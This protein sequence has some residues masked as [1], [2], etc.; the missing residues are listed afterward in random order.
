MA[1]H[2]CIVGGMFSAALLG[3]FCLENIQLLHWEEEDCCLCMCGAQELTLLLELGSGSSFALDL[4]Y[5]LDQSIFF[6]VP[7]HHSIST[8]RG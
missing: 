8:R 4:K 2:F 5:D 1:C 6:S 7:I 3:L